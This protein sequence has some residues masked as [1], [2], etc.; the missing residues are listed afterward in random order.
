MRTMVVDTY[1][2]SNLPLPDASTA[3]TLCGPAG[4]CKYVEKDGIDLQKSFIERIGSNICEVFDEKMAHVLAKPLIWAAFEDSVGDQRL[5][6][7]SL[8]KKILEMFRKEG[9]STEINPVE[10]VGIQPTGNGTDMCF[11]ELR[12]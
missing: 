3:A 9:L 2:S 1:I 5:L 12:T 7:G 8:K 10:R 6:P 11:L 4:A